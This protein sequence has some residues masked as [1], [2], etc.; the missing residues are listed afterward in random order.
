MHPMRPH[1][2]YQL[3]LLE[4]TD[5]DITCMILLKRK[6]QTQIW[7]FCI[8]VSMVNSKVNFLF[9]ITSC[10]Y[11]KNLKNKSAL[12][13]QENYEHIK[14]SNKI[15]RIINLVI[16]WFVIRFDNEHWRLAKLNLL[17]KI[18]LRKDLQW[19]KVK[20]RN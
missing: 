8:K 17:I 6:I 18:L 12:W 13:A 9:S 1:I 11:L 5:D 14:L 15:L 2:V 20:F 4:E 7:R 19:E 16:W 10:W 3:T